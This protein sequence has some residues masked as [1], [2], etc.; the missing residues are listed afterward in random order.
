VHLELP[1]INSLLSAKV[2]VQINI[3]VN[4]PTNYYR[5]LQLIPR[6]SPSDAA[7]TINIP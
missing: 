6:S 3:A 7:Y 2:G 4:K 5:W 1:W